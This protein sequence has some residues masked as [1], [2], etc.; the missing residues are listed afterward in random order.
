MY[1]KWYDIFTLD[2]N[3]TDTLFSMYPKWK[4]PDSLVIF[5]FANHGFFGVMFLILFITY[6]VFFLYKLRFPYLPVLISLFLFIVS[7]KGNFIFNNMG[8]F[9]L[10]FIIYFIVYNESDPSYCKKS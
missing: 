3:L 4:F 8:M 10:I 1:F 5:Y 9:L 6:L 2:A 7:F